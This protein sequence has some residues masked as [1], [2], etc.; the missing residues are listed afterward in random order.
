MAQDTVRKGN[1]RIGRVTTR[2]YS[3]IALMIVQ[4]LAEL[5]SDQDSLASMIRGEACAMLR[6]GNISGFNRLADVASRLT[7][8]LYPES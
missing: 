3:P 2:A 7:D 6:K 8:E 5:D 1:G 4:A